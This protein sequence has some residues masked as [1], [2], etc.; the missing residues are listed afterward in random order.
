MHRPP[1]TKDDRGSE[2][3][4]VESIFK[5]R[6]KGAWMGCEREFHLVCKGV[7][8]AIKKTNAIRVVDVGCEG[9]VG[10]L[11]HV[12]DKL[13]TEFRMV[14]L[15]CVV[16]KEEEEERVYKMYGAVEGV[17]V[18]VMDAYTAKFPNKTD[19]L[20]AYRL[21]EKGT[22]IDAM[23]FFQ[24]VKK[25]NAVDVLAMESYPESRN[26]PG[27]NSGNGK[28]RINAALAPFWFP[29]PVYEYEN[30][31]EDPDGDHMRIVAIKVAEMFK[32]RATPEMKDLVDPRKRHVVE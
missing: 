8:R 32:T 14:N 3:E 2:G 18:V 24:N 21:L 6:R 22:L 30:V 29:P 28:L 10:W 9:N 31:E 13:R 5:A 20:V 7:Y 16:G 25:E 27:E 11:P 17:S 23:R 26:V 19:M 15:I 12:V 4:G 1:E